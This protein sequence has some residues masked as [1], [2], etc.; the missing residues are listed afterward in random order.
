M[1][2]VLRLAP[3]LW[4]FSSNVSFATCE[5]RIEAIP[6]AQTKSG[7]GPLIQQSELRSV[8]LDPPEGVE[9]R[10]DTVLTVNLEYRIAD[11][12]AG[13]FRILPLYK[14]GVTSSNSFDDNDNEEGI[15]LGTAA[16]R[17]LLCLPLASLYEKHALEVTWPLELFIIILK[18]DPQGGGGRGVAMSPPFKLNAAD[19]PVAAL[20]RQAKAPP[21]EVQ[22]ALESAFNNFTTRA[23][24]YK[25]CIRK[26]PQMQARLTPAYR[27]WESRNK[28]DIE[29]VSALQFE[30]L[31][32]ESGGDAQG[33]MTRIDQMQA[34]VSTFF[35]SW[36]AAQLAPQCDDI[37]A[38]TDPKEV[39]L[40]LARDLAT[41]RKWRPQP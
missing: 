2:N 35:E 23:A 17:V 15:E 30:A 28:A 14:T 31:K 1:V 5:S 36:T 32:E 7:A 3:L 34:G 29:W 41:L 11:F 24:T 40:P 20:E 39:D 6:I 38:Q 37:I 33:A 26:F 25:L 13:K 27:T 16:G 9:V 18:L 12:A 8:T 22:L 19:V 21:K 4:L 10:A